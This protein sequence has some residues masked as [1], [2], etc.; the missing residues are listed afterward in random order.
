MIGDLERGSRLLG[1]SPSRSLLER[2]SALPTSTSPSIDGRSI[3]TG[4][5]DRSTAAMDFASLLNPSPPRA[6]NTPPFASTSS[7]VLD[8]GPHSPR[9]VDPASGVDAATSSAPG[10]AAVKDEEADIELLDGRASGT[11]GEG[12]GRDAAGRGSPAVSFASDRA[13]GGSGSPSRRA[14]EDDSMDVDQDAVI[15][16]AGRVKGEVDTQDDE[17]VARSPRVRVSAAQSGGRVPLTRRPSASQEVQ[18]AGARR[19]GQRREGSSSSDGFV[20]PARVDRVP[21][22][23]SWS[24]GR[25]RERG[26]AD[27]R[28]LDGR[29]G[30]R[31]R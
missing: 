19:Q 15:E 30:R 16:L 4:L 18:G 20:E 29:G 14:R 5:C 31:G 25:R 24:V 21:S 26:P 22:R 10:G 9:P 8:P 6:N 17:E 2:D 12:S 7:A 28:R 1:P 13:V 27:A 3:S 11:R 23:Q